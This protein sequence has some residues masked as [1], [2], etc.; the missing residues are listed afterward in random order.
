M[1]A[2]QPPRPRSGHARTHYQIL[3]VDP[4]ASAEEIRRAF[5][6][7]AKQHHPD[8][9]PAGSAE[10]FAAI[11]AAYETLSDPLLRRAYDESLTRDQTAERAAGDTRAHYAWDNIGAPRAGN[12]SRRPER[13]EFDDLY[14]TFYTDRAPPRDRG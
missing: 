5:R 12:A 13:A 1:T 7:L 3:G 6:S 2:R 11:A 8:T 14:D 4:R 9:G 10:A